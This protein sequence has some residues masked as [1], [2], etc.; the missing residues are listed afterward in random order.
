[1]EREVTM[2]LRIVCLLA[3]LLVLGTAH[4]YPQSAQSGTPTA[5]SPKPTTAKTS[6]AATQSHEDDGQ[7]VFEQNCSRCHTTPDGF[8]PRISGTVVRHMRARASLSRR[9]E[10]AILK[11]FNP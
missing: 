8:S 10:E 5:Q 11:F 9:D 6:V 3:S 2:K 4:A 1:M 7:R